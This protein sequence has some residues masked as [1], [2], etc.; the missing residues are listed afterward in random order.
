MRSNLTSKL[1][2]P[3]LCFIASTLGIS[4]DL[5]SWC[6][7]EVLFGVLG[8]RTGERRRP[9][10]IFV[11][12]FTFL[13]GP[14]KK[15]AC[16]KKS[17]LLSTRTIRLRPRKKICCSQSLNWGG[18]KWL[19]VLSCLLRRSDTYLP[20]CNCDTMAEISKAVKNLICLCTSLTIF[21][22][23]ILNCSNKSKIAVLFRSIYNSHPCG[24]FDSNL[25]MKCFQS[26]MSLQRCLL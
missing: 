4:S 15:W 21:S 5:I 13:S 1:K 25:I 23:A 6:H 8:E 14:W 2:C 16:G 11:R 3:N 18:G 7:L 26:C 9:F 10:I 20:Y 19:V 12:V 24:Y 17:A 22:K